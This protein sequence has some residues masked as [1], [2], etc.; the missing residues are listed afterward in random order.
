MDEVHKF[1]EEK[2]LGMIP[3]GNHPQEQGRIWV[4]T[5]K[6]MDGFFDVFCVFFRHF[7]VPIFRPLTANSFTV[8]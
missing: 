3:G 6:M 7:A 8:C 4:S 1:I 5:S 2:A